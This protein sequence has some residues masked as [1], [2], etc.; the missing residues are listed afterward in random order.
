MTLH[1]RFP[2]TQQPGQAPKSAEKNPEVL[3][4]LTK[5]TLTIERERY[6][7]K[8]YTMFTHHKEVDK[9]VTKNPRGLVRKPHMVGLSTQDEETQLAGYETTRDASMAHT[10]ALILPFSTTTAMGATLDALQDNHHDD[11]E[12]EDDDPGSRD[13]QTIVHHHHHNN[14]NSQAI[15]TEP[16]DPTS[17]VE[18]LYTKTA[19]A[20]LPNDGNNNHGTDRP[21]S[22]KPTLAKVLIANGGKRNDRKSFGRRGP[23]NVVDESSSS[24]S[25]SSVDEND[26][27]WIPPTTLHTPGFPRSSTSSAKSLSSKSLI[28]TTSSTSARSSRGYRKKRPARRQSTPGRLPQDSIQDKDD[29][30]NDDDDGKK[31]PNES[32]FSP[33]P[34]RKS[35]TLKRPFDEEPSLLKPPP[36]PSGPVRSEDLST[37]A[38]AA[39]AASVVVGN[40]QQTASTVAYGVKHQDQDIKRR[41]DSSLPR[42]VASAQSRAAAKGT[43]APSLYP[44]VEELSII[45]NQE[46]LAATTV[47][48]SV[49]YPKSIK[50]RLSQISDLDD[51][52]SKAS[53]ALI[54]LDD[55]RNRQQWEEVM[56]YAGIISEDTPNCSTEVV[57]VTDGD[58]DEQKMPAKQVTV[59]PAEDEAAAVALKDN[60]ENKLTYGCADDIPNLAS[61]SDMDSSGPFKVEAA[62]P[63]S[64]AAIVEMMSHDQDGMAPEGDDDDFSYS[65]SSDSDDFSRES[66]NAIAIGWPVALTEV[67]DSPEPSEQGIEVVEPPCAPTRQKTVEEVTQEAVSTVVALNIAQ[68]EHDAKMERKK[69]NNIDD[70]E[71][72]EDEIDL[73]MAVVRR[74]SSQLP[75]RSSKSLELRASIDHSGEFSL[76]GVAEPRASL[77]SNNGASA[78][79]LS[80]GSTGRNNRGSP[81]FGRARNTAGLIDDNGSA[82]GETSGEED[83]EAQVGIPVLPGAV[84]MVGIDAQEGRQLSGY[85]SGYDDESVGSGPTRPLPPPQEEDELED[86]ENPIPGVVAELHEVEERM[87]VQAQVLEAGETSKFA[88][89]KSRVVQV[90]T[91]C[92]VLAMAAIVAVIVL[93]GRTSASM[94]SAPIFWSPIGRD[95]TVSEPQ[96]DGIFFGQSISMSSDGL[97]LVV[98]QPGY[99]DSA[100]ELAVGRVSL[101]DWTGRRWVTRSEWSGPSEQARFGESVAISKEGHRVIIGSPKWQ[102]EQGRVTVYDSVPVGNDTSQEASSWPQLGQILLGKNLTASQGGQ[103]GSAVAIS[104]DGSVIAVAA[105]TSAV[106][107]QLDSGTVSVYSLVGNSTW[108]QMGNEIFGDVAST[109]GASIALSA[110]GRRI[111]IG[112]PRYE[113]G[114]GDVRVFDFNQGSWTQVGQS[115]RGAIASFGNMGASVSLSGDGTTLAIGAPRSAG[116]NGRPSSGR[117]KVYRF[118]DQQMSW[119]PLGRDLFGQT[120]L[121]WFGSALQLSSDANVLAVGSPSRRMTEDGELQQGLVRTFLFDQS[122]D[123]VEHGNGIFGDAPPEQFGLSVALSAD[124]KRMGVSAPQAD[125]DG[126]KRQVGKVRVFERL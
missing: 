27:R 72:G 114:V 85:D 106:N 122:G 81:S 41:S 49:A 10:G 125:F 24:S 121:E 78:L 16:V 60:R 13:K 37:A 91:L 36:P 5:Y 32:S 100:T 126:R 22:T 17:N 108:L 3:S 65:H 45:S 124:G 118:D 14:S 19:V 89:L 116:T 67:D 94:D 1:L 105:R 44:D 6:P 12:D 15:G 9:T 55:Y 103:F 123:W 38:A 50:S 120:A 98:G 88:F 7:K 35:S 83:L 61:S 109:F 111:A 112:A 70:E 102:S 53:A 99:S 64:N 107:G 18:V 40:A 79:D 75:F 63:R 86:E 39:A 82:D 23:R 92:A 117:V 29:D 84:A 57:L 56:I 74:R 101:L 48:S 25:S 68:A 97:R 33:A 47:A 90:G 2:A 46:S 43:T 11:D 104:D 28:T 59:H 69:A 30:N 87:L 71:A 21:S 93:F 58:E 80:F 96:S 8:D 54:D 4:L 73:M 52:S 76:G 34:K 66:A 77:N 31:M 62:R 42:T 26:I 113:Q 115:I 95:I 20:S 110:N 51:M 119:M